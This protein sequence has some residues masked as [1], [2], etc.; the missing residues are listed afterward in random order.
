MSPFS[1]RQNY[2]LKTFF[3][4]VRTPNNITTWERE[5]L[6]FL[7][8]VGAAAYFQLASNNKQRD[9]LEALGR[10]GLCQR[11]L[12]QGEKNIKIAS[13]KLYKEPSSL[14]RTL[15]FTQL[16]KQLSVPMEVTPGEGIIH[17]V[18]HINDQSFPVAVLRHND[19]V[20]LLPFMV[21]N[22]NRLII[23]SEDYHPEFDKITIPVRIALDEALLSND[24]H[25]LLPGGRREYLRKTQDYQHQCKEGM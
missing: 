2:T 15:V 17:S 22:Y 14:L 8:Q 12:L 13:S 20:S 11:Y 18:I 10:A 16:V 21:R 24:F 1:T 19:S 9:K 7:S 4:D 25:F 6:S 23:I 5:T 3:N